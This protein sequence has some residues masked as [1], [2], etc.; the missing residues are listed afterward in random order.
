MAEPKQGAA[1]VARSPF[2]AL[3]LSFRLVRG[4]WRAIAL[5]AAMLLAAILVFVLLTGIFTGV[6][7]GL[8]GQADPTTQGLAFSRWLMALV[9]AL[10][11]V[12]GGAVTVIAW[13]AAARGV[14]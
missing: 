7:M 3:A 10:P 14:H 13:R 12:Y 5:I 9:L 2:S 6:V 8:A 11:V 1:S 4:R